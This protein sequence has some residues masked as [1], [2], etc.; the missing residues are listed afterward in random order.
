MLTAAL[1]K[2][3]P[4]GAQRIPQWP[5][6][7][8]IGINK[9][10]AIERALEAQKSA[11]HDAQRAAKE[12]KKATDAG[13]EEEDYYA[14]DGFWASLCSLKRTLGESVPENY[15][16]PEHQGNPVVC[17]GVMQF[18]EEF[19]QHNLEDWLG[20]CQKDAVCEVVRATAALLRAVAAG[21]GEHNSE[22]AQVPCMVR[23]SGLAGK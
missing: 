1:R 23:V 4:G 15:A 12:F 17:N 18:A 5:E 11:K 6:P 2:T 8:T 9:T 20:A 7:C 16:V 21:D 13:A 22:W 14:T 19:L 10:E 3:T